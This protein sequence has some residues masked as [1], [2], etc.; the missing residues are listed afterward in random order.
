MRKRCQHISKW[1]FF[2]AGMIL[3]AH[4]VIAHHHHFDSLLS[5]HESA[6]CESHPNE[7][8]EDAAEHCHAFNNIVLERTNDNLQKLSLNLPNFHVD[9]PKLNLKTGDAVPAPEINKIY[10]HSILPRKLHLT[11]QQQLRAPPALI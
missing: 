5:H 1:L 2:L 10:F 8:N 4:A 11:S 6:A 7:S 9:I 3:F